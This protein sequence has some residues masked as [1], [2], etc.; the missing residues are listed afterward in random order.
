MQLADF[1]FELPVEL[2]ARYPATERTQS[3][4]M[5]IGKEI[6]HHI[7]ADVI[8]FINQGDLVIFNDTKVIPARLYGQKKTGG[9]VEVLVERIL[10]DKSILAQMRVSKTPRVGDFILFA[11]DIRLQVIGRAEKFFQLRYNLNDKTILQI[12]ELIGNIPLPPYMQREAEESD[13]ERYQTVYAKH[14]GS[15][16]GPTAGFHFDKNLLTKLAEKQVN[17]AYLT[18]HI[19]AGTF[20]PV[21]VENIVEHKMHA[22]YFE[23]SEQ[24]CEQIKK[25]KANGKR[26]IVVGTTTMRALESACASGEL[27]PFKGD[28]NIFI[29][30]GY[31][32]HIAD[33][34]ITN[35]HLPGSTLLMLVSAFGGHSQMM[36]AY[37]E[38][39]KNNYRFYSYG[40]AMWISQS[41]QSITG[42]N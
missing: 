20:L 2:I 36:Q 26:V 10:D 32:F 33:A 25:T 15:V 23:V 5:K 13:K 19:G 40:D 31:K 18:L 4:L 24:V 38:A 1:E 22:E 12:I 35:L 3:K 28:T 30:P 9:K 21:R 16:A 34:L 11:N 17:T 39:V 27:K 14:D 37:A 6:S 29:Y 42:P 7:F 41:P 8:D